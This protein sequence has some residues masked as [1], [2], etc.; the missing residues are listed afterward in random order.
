M[1]KATFI[2]GVGIALV[3]SIVV[4]AL[5]TTISPLFFAGELFRVLVA[6][7]TFFYILYLFLRSKER[8]GRITVI[9][10]WFVITLSS[11][12]FVTSLL[13]YIVIQ[14][15]MIWLIRSLY[16]YNSLF[17][18]LTDLSLTGLSLVVAISVWL[19]SGSLFLTFWC[20]FL[21]QALFVFIPKKIT[22]N[23]KS[24]YIQL[25]IGDR[26]EHAYH[27]AEIAVSKLINSK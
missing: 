19:S 16:F 26:F 20:F 2:E 6:G 23:R 21:V 24:E 3:S 10:I 15:L 1:K 17:S 9:S 7:L 11:F 13:L 12:I 8:T 27:T 5:F 14:L 22:S 25:P 4:A 18:S